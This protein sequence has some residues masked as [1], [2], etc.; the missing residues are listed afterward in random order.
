MLHTTQQIVNYINTNKNNLLIDSGNVRCLYIEV[1]EKLFDFIFTLTEF[2]PTN[3]QYEI[4]NKL[5]SLFED[6][7]FFGDQIFNNKYFIH[8]SLYEDFADEEDL[9]YLMSK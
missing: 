9:D 1:S 5:S 6:K 4:V 7:F 3:F 2:S 8:L